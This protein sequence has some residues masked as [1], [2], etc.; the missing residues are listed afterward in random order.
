[1]MR[2]LTKPADDPAT[3]R[4]YLDTTLRQSQDR[5]RF[6]GR[7]APVAALRSVVGAR[8]AGP[9]QYN[10]LAGRRFTAS[11]HRER[12][13]ND[14]AVP[15]AYAAWID[16]LFFLNALMARLELR[17]DE[18]FPEERRGLEL[19]HEAREAFWRRHALCHGCGALIQRGGTCA[20]C[21]LEF[22]GPNRIPR[23]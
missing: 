6:S 22:A 7:R 13:L 5:D 17:P 1:M 18:I 10:S 11:V 20:T 3:L 16:Y 12:P 19:L 4:R 14:A 2:I 15:Y 9:D 8:S 21:S 23:R